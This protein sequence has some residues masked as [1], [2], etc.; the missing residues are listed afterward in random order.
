MKTEYDS[1]LIYDFLKDIVEE[2]ILTDNV[3][4]SFY[5]FD[6]FHYNDIEIDLNY[7]ILKKI[8]RR[9][10]ERFIEKLTGKNIK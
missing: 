4:K 1:S 5:K 7:E 8:L 2:I 3:F 10:L 9:S 6:D